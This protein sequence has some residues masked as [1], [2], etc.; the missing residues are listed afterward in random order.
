M[1]DINRKPNHLI[2]ETSPYLQA[3]AHNPVNWY[4]WGDEAFERAKEENKLIFLS[5]GYH[6]CHWCHVMEQ[7]SFEDEQ[8]AKIL[9][10][11]FIA[12]KVDREERKDIDA[13]Y[14]KACQMITGRGGWPLN[15][16]L[17]PDRLPVYAGTYFPRKTIMNRTGLIDVCDY[18]MT[19]YK[20][21][22][23][24][25][26]N[27]SF[28][29]ITSL[30]RAENH[31]E[32]TLSDT[33]IE[34]TYTELSKSF[35]PDYG[36]FSKAPKFPSPHQI[37]LSLESDHKENVKQGIKTLEHMA[38]GGIYDH[39]GGG[40]SRYSVDNK[41]LIPHFEKMLYDN[42][43][44]LDA[45]AK[46]YAITENAV[47]KQIID[48]TVRFVERD[49]GH[50]DGGF[51]SAYDADSEGVEGKFYRFTV[52]E[53]ENVLGEEAKGFMK[54]YNVSKQGNFEGFNVLNLINK[55][56]NAMLDPQNVTLR[57]MLFDYR[58]KR[59]K[60]ALDDKI[61]SM[62][63]GFMIHGLVEVYKKVSKEKHILELAINAYQYI[64]TYMLNDDYIL[65]ASV[66]NNQGTTEGMIDDYS[67][68]IRGVLSLYEVTQKPEY[69]EDALH[70]MGKTI[71]LFYDEEH[72]GFFVGSKENTGLIYNPKEI[73][74]G[75]TPS[76][77]SLMAMNL[78][79]CY[80]L[81]EDISYKSFLD[82]IL[83]SF[84]Y[85]LNRYKQFAA[86]FMRVVVGLTKGT[87]ELKLYLPDQSY[88]DEAVLW[89]N[90]QGNDYLVKKVM[91][92]PELC[93]ED[94][95]TKYHCANMTCLQ[96]E[97]VDL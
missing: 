10:E 80:L 73:Y 70:L 68:V 75:A 36:G 12:I 71:E 37:L 44:L 7:E 82:S 95:P 33:L 34:D 61:L 41:W 54:L 76:G 46:A 30:K 66:R 14:M 4:P 49:L 18:L 26:M 65:L 55:D 15:L 52:N 93:L 21:Q 67:A 92:N 38:K 25:I 17:T 8:V 19:V 42:G 1:E 84:S 16:W 23:N 47:F 5:I 87:K 69:L 22:P 51:Y 45:Y 88:M 91:V 63:N 13:I 28:E 43:L 53:I 86:Y 58:E 9:N 94:K 96:P 48:E 32:A 85:H 39:L 6:A 83:D 2:N 62:S 40:F 79:K 64:K 57:S 11:N 56:L 31:K 81:T 59:I 50:V 90:N 60:P 35:D 78:L 89:L 20:E 27:Q 97:I 77:N 3:H 29:I 74:D 72:G 24:K